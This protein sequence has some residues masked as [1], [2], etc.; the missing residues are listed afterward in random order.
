MHPAD[1]DD[2]DDGAPRSTHTP[3]LSDRHDRGVAVG[4]IYEVTIADEISR[5]VIGANGVCKLGDADMRLPGARKAERYRVRVIAVGVNQW[6][7]RMEATVQKLAGP[8]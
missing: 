5:P 1:P 2:P 8:L 3:V 4:Q 6:T 7:G